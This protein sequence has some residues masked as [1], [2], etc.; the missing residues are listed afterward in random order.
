MEA[1]PNRRYRAVRHDGDVSLHG[2]YCLVARGRWAMNAANAIIIARDNLADA[3]ADHYGNAKFCLDMA[4][5]WLERGNE[6]YAKRHA[7][8]S[9]AY[10]LGVFSIVYREASL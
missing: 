5:D 7:L 9:I 1:N 2:N 4:E 10:S 8:R 6:K 3:P